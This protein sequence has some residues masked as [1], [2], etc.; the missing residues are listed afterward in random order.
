MSQLVGTTPSLGGRGPTCLSPHPWGNSKAWPE[1]GETTQKYL[2]T[3]VI[4]MDYFSLTIFFSI[5]LSFCRFVWWPLIF[6]S[7]KLKAQ[8]SFSD[9]LLC[10]SVNFS[11]FHLLRLHWANFNP[12]LHTAYLDEE[13]LS[14]FKWRNTPFSKGRWL[15]KQNSKNSLTTLKKTSPEP[16]DQFQPNW[17]EASLSEDDSIFF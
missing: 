12:T 7:S 5:D 11:Y 4:W 8:V 6:S 17:H 16:L 1:V 2:L 3:N 13:H 9:R 10:L 15:H 14:L